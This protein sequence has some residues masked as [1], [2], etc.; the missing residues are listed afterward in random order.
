MSHMNLSTLGAHW[1]RTPRPVQFALELTVAAFLAVGGSCLAAKAGG[2]LNAKSN[3][4][5]RSSFALVR[6]AEALER[7]YPPPTSPRSSEE[8]LK[9]NPN[10]EAWT[11]DE[12]G[13]YR[14]LPTRHI[15]LSEIPGWKKESL[16]L[17][18]DIHIITKP[19]P[20]PDPCF[21]TRAERCGGL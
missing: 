13:V 21:V 16:R 4:D 3:A 6:I 9:Q 5:V 7:K 14:C 17:A 19:D 18:S 20:D 8:L 15:E 2:K 12:D 10:C 11:R 1:R